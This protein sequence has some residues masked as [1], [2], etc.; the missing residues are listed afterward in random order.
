MTIISE[1]GEELGIGRIRKGGDLL[2]LLSSPSPERI[3]HRVLENRRLLKSIP[4]GLEFAT[5]LA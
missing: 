1:T 3:D 2:V 4:D 5:V